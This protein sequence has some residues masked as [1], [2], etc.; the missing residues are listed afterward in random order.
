MHYLGCVAGAFQMVIGMSF[1]L[2]AGSNWH[3]TI[4]DEKAFLDVDVD[5]PSV[6]TIFGMLTHICF[7]IGELNWGVG[8]TVMMNALGYTAPLSWAPCAMMMLTF[9]VFLFGFGYGVTDFGGPT[10]L[11]ITG[12]PFPTV[13]F[14]ILIFSC[15]QANAVYQFVAGGKNAIIIDSGVDLAPK[16]LNMKQNYKK[17][18]WVLWAI[19]W[20]VPQSP[21]AWQRATLPDWRGYPIVRES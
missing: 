16:F 6:R 5:N 14:A 7:F 2:T 13:Q 21:A 15:V 19:A 1:Y 17:I 10:G 12:P 20:V 18:Y 3:Q 11:P 9:M 8:Y 4:M